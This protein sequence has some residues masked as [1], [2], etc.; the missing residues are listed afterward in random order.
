M[1]YR[2]SKDVVYNNFPWPE[3]DGA[4]REAIEAAARGVLDAR[5]MWPDSSLADLYDATT[6]PV[7]LR[8]AHKALD[9]IVERAYGFGRSATEGEIARELLSRYSRMAARK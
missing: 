4:T 3:A 9:A 1:R 5:E 8:R 7:E 6:M 2:Y